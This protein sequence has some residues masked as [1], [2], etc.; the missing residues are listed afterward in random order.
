VKKLLLCIVALAGCLPV[1]AQLVINE[2]MQSN[3]DCVMDDLNEFPDSWVELY[4]TGSTAVN[5]RDYSL[6]VSEKPG[7]AWQLPDVTVGPR[8]YAMVYC[9]KEGDG[10][11][12]SYRLE[13]GKGCEVWLFSG[14]D[15]AD[16]V[17]GLKKQPAPNIAYGRKTDGGSDWGYQT[18]ATPGAKN[19]GETADRVLGDP[20]FSEQGRVVTDGTKLTLAI[21]LPEGCPEG[22]EIYMTTD[23]TEPTRESVKY[24]APLTIGNT[25][26]VRARLF[27]QGWLSP[28]AVT[29]SYIYFTREMKLPIISIA[30]D[31]KY[32]TDPKIGIYVEGS[33]QRG[34]NNYE[35]NWRRPMNIEM[36]DAD[37]QPSVINQLCEAR[38]AGG[39][40][41]NS[42][43]KSMAVYSHK[44]FGKKHFDYEFFPDQKP[45]IKEFKSIMLR[46]SGNDFDYL[47]MRD[48]I[49]QRTMASHVDLD[50]QAWQPAVVYF[51]GVYKGMLNIRERSNEDNIWSNYQKLEDIDM[52]EN[53]NEL[54]EG[55]WENFNRLMAFAREEGHT[56][57]EY[58][59]WMDCSEYAD[60]MLANLYFNNLDTPGNNWM[61]WRPR[62]EGGR[63]RF[64]AK[65]MDFTLGLYD[66]T[67]QYKI[68]EWLY[69]PNFDSS[70]N[71]GANSS[72]AT[73]F[74][75]QLMEDEDFRRLFIDRAAI[76]MGDFLNVEGVREVWDPMYE[77]FRTEF[78]HHRKLYMHNQWWP[79]NYE[80]ELRNARYWLSKRTDI[81]YKQLASFYNLGSPIQMKINTDVDADMDLTFNGIQLSKGRFDGKY[82]KDRKVT[83][84]G[85]APEGQTIKGWNVF[86]VSSAG[87]VTKQVEG[88]QC[89]FVMPDC[90]SMVINAI[91]ADPSAIERID[92]NNWTWHRDGGNI[93]LSGVPSGMRVGLYDMR[94]MTLH[95]QVADGSD[96]II[97]LPSSSLCILKVGGKATVCSGQ[98]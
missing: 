33:Y 69:N 58:E 38:I 44:R 24:G 83:I 75:R 62:A 39:A 14:Q 9:D 27:C 71:W 43:L 93:Y 78:T 48:P 98:K 37:G 49:V 51:N 46:N 23:G 7:E 35:F 77:Y 4:N 18:E 40:T 34:K 85:R 19:C 63:W 30:I 28:R 81:F 56:L 52:V 11:H 87:A 31:N 57:A 8:Q 64:V 73:L 53:W 20:V 5:L 65:D 12:T 6:G 60:L 32:L 45:G 79:R 17:T 16:R 3:V 67:P 26:V 47:Y 29:Q 97:P 10:L 92:S 42:G 15:V 55:D 90:T 68:I 1:S 2:L 36:F 86:T 54:K 91:L 22:T 72:E 82:F 88:Q 74:F 96:I 84:E 41:R 94:G 59:Q 89:S 13:S 66:V 70:H 21:S 76:Y 25:K 80:D 61:M 50:W 95:S